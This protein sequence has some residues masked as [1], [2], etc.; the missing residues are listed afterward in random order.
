VTQPPTEHPPGL[1]TLNAN[2]GRRIT[3]TFAYIDDLLQTVER[4][5]RAQASAFSREQPDLSETEARLLLALVDTARSR[6]LATLD[7]LGLPRPEANL[8]TRWSITTALRFIDVSLS[9]LT[10]QVLGGYGAIDRESAT[11]VSAVASKL[12]EVVARGRALLQPEEGEEL[13]ERVSGIAGSFGEVLRRAEELSTRLGL[14][15]VRPLISAAA[16]RANTDTIEIGIFGRVSSGK[17][18]LINA[19]AGAA[20][21]PVGATPVTAVPLRV[22]SGPDVVRVYFEDGREQSIAAGALAEFATET[23]NRDNVRSVRSILI[24]TPRLPEGLALLDTPG[25]G[26]LSRSGPAQA[27]AWLPRCDLGIVLVAAGTPLGRDELALVRGLTQAG[28]ALEVF[29]SKSDLVQASERAPTLQYLRNEI[30]AATGAS[31]ITVHAVSVA[32]TDRHLLDQ[33]RERELLPLVAERRRAAETA[34]GRRV[35]ALLGALNAALLG[36]PALER[37]T[38]DLHRARTIALRE[39]DASADE[40]E[41]AA[42]VSLANAADAAAT[43]WRSGADVQATVRQMLLEAPGRAALRVRAAADEVVDGADST[44][45]GDA[46]SR[47][48][49]LF[50]PPFL[51]ALPIAPRPGVSGRLFARATARHQLDALAKPLDEAYRLFAGRVRAW[52]IARLEGNFAWADATRVRDAG[53]T[54]PELRPLKAYVDEHFPARPA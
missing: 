6:M 26:S 51:D 52:G 46:A 27:F 45:E 12:R 32:A 42:G 15:E 14:V 49:P 47:I 34:R 25:V 36:R 39:I 2:Q 17:S 3:S 23:G 1:A 8:S 43:A 9:E 29:L 33:W 20:L 38:V 16:G 5:A 7:H 10:P 41:S 21:L 19:L 53:E 40:L 50:D 35:R 48:P 24:R 11:E 54:A 13:H 28:I 31:D 18:S 44:I 22:V 37:A 4:L 30:T